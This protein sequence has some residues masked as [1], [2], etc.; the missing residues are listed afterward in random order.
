MNRKWKLTAVFMAFLWSLT[1]CTS[2]DKNAPASSVQGESEIPMSSFEINTKTTGVT[3]LQTEEA[4]KLN[5]M[6]LFIGDKSFSVT[7]EE[8]DTVQALT[9]L[10][11]MTLVMSELN[12]NE[13]YSYLDTSL[14]STPEMVGTIS[15]GDVMLYG[16]NC[17]V[18]FYKSFSTPYRYTRIGR[19]DDTAGLADALGNSGVTIT[20]QLAENETAELNVQD[21]YN[22]RDFLLAKPTSEDLTGKQYDL[23]GDGVW[24]AFDLCLMKRRLIEQSETAKEISI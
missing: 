18:V 11:P 2:V 19:I 17:L 13:K 23:D 15:E 21:V 9:E 12:E 1:A 20:F 14:P 10:L 24:N 6:Q 8:N 16:D 22:L 5:R 4:R 7:L 3:A